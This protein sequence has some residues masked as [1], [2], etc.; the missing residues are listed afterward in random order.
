MGRKSSRIRRTFTPG[1]KRD[2]VRLVDEGKTVTEVARD[3]G[4]A[5][6]LL[7]RWKDQ[8]AVA[9]APQESLLRAGFV[10]ERIRPPGCHSQSSA[11]AVRAMELV[12]SLHTR[13]RPA[14][15]FHV[16][17]NTR[18][19]KVYS[20]PLHATQRRSHSRSAIA[21]WNGLKPYVSAS[22]IMSRIASLSN[23]RHG[24]P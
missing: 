24:K 21:G 4:I 18:Q 23:I 5:R 22:A 3:L 6:S 19:M 12:H 11:T 17:R 7:Q 15:R 10:R 13:P 8:L 1:F 20:R 2:A 14:W 16:L 9:L